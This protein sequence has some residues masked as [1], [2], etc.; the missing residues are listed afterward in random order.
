MKLDSESSSSRNS[1]NLVSGNL[2]GGFLPASVQQ[3]EHEQNRNSNLITE[4]SD[5][6]ARRARSSDADALLQDIFIR[7]N[8]SSLSSSMATVVVAVVAA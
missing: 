3:Q 7:T 5:E 8:T 1:R 4:S 2:C 6:L